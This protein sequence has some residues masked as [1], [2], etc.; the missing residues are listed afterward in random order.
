MDIRP[1]KI[2]EDYEAALIEVEALMDAEPDTPEGDRLD[3]WV[4]LIENYESKH[5]PIDLPDPVSAIAFVMERRGL[6][7]KDLVPCIGRLNRVYEVL[8][9]KRG[10][11]LRMIRN[12]HE[13]L[14]IPLDILLRS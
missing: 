10:L 8:N 6:T 5:F 14:N 4:T 13:S 3:I 9:Y 12:I 7:P 1:I 2:N 11:S